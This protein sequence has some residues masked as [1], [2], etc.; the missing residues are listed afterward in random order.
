[1]KCLS[2]QKEDRYQNMEELQK[3]LGRYLK[4]EYKKSLKESRTENNMKRSAHYCCELFMVHVKLNEPAD[5]LKY[6]MDMQNYA[7]GDEIRAE[8]E[9]LVKELKIRLEK[10]IGISDEFMDKAKV[11]AHQVRMGW[12]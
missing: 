10:D 4:I 12:G 5:A 3:E 6:C 7:G 9:S 8:I 1:M 11:L 2:K